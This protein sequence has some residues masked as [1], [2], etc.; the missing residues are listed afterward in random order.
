MK[1]KSPPPM[2]M[3]DRT[4]HRRAVMKKACRP[5]LILALS[6]LLVACQLQPPWSVGASG[7]AQPSTP[8]RVEWT[9]WDGDYTLL[10]AHQLG[11]FEK[12][13]LTVEPVYYHSFPDTLPDLAGARLDIGLLGIVDA[14]NLANR[15]DA[16][17]IAVYDTGGLTSL[18][19]GPEINRPTE[20]RGKRIGVGFGTSGEMVVRDILRRAGLTPLD[21]TLVD[22]DASQVPAALR[23]RRVQAG[24]TYEPYTTQALQ[25]GARLLANSPLSALLPDVI[26]VR[27]DLARQRPEAVRAFLAA[28]FEAVQYRLDHPQESRQIIAQRTGH[29]EA[30]LAA[31]LAGGDLTLYTLDDN[32]RLYAGSA[33]AAQSIYQIAR[34]NLDFMIAS[35]SLTTLLDI[36]RIFDSAYLP[37]AGTTAALGSAA[38]AGDFAAPVRTPRAP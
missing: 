15:I 3:Q 33:A 25:D 17:V 4:F 10:V 38:S 13:G 6:A 27:G 30:D 16:R 5:W 37:I 24:V 35:G 34:T 21:V 14:L 2:P 11:L 28:W 32:R 31:G 1:P 20:L 7:T 19:A 12:H 18:V 23:Q 22:L 26:V 9:D 29:S 8:L 36:R